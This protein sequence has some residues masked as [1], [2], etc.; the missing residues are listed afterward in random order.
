[1]EFIKLGLSSPILKTLEEQSY[2]T[3][4]AIQEKAIPAILE[5]KDVLGLA[6]TGTG[7]TAAYALPTLQLLSQ[8]MRSPFSTPISTLVLVPTREL[9]IQISNS[10][11]IYGK[12]LSLKNMAIFGGTTQ[13]NQVKAL[14]RN[15]DILIATPGR[16]VDLIRNRHVDISAV[17]IFILDEADT[18]LDMGFS[19]ELQ[20]IMKHLPDKKQTLLFSATMTNEMK[21]MA[22]KILVN[23]VIASI[24]PEATMK[25]NVD[26]EIY[27]VR[28]D[29][30]MDVL[31]DF[32][33]KNTTD[34]VIIF[35]KTKKGADE[36]VKELT[37]NK[38]A[39]K[40]F[41]SDKSQEERKEAL[42]NFMRKKIRALVATDIAS[43]GINI[44]DLK[45]VINYDLPNTIE[46][47]IHRIGRTGRAG[48]RGIAISYCTNRDAQLLKEIEKREEDI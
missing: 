19:N 36:V 17:E 24:V 35:T 48:A 37:K 39:A 31:L 29:E 21:E 38:V 11:T 30:K 32:F 10:F 41:H 13:S 16:L 42:N 45:Y 25:N 47:Y 3:S 14:K 18:M 40:A 26:E 20:E 8:T 33:W 4:T 44:D 28:Q 7:K 27:L 43:R 9:A 46:T 6:H 1:M 22:D 23:P 2:T 12:Y 5:G 34:S 15:I